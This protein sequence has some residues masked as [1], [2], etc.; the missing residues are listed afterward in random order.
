MRQG[1]CEQADSQPDGAGSWEQAAAAA[2]A[3]GSSA[4]GPQP[5]C[6][7]LLFARCVFTAHLSPARRGST[8]SRCRPAAALSISPCPRRRRA[9]LPSWLAPSALP[10]TTAAAIAAWR[11]CRRVS[12]RPPG[13]WSGPWL[14]ARGAARRCRAAPRRAARVDAPRRPAAPPPPPRP[15]RPPP[16]SDAR[17]PSVHSLYLFRPA[18][19]RQPAEGVQGQPG[20]VPAPRRQ[21]QGGRRLGRGAPR[22]LGLLGCLRA[23]GCAGLAA[24]G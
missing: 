23:A 19:E 18:G 4:L 20:G 6:F 7:P 3:A 16:A 15:A 12:G 13:G 9:S 2:R 17:L 5:P 8:R 1:R 24:A 10:W 14:P 22:L 21:A 11:A